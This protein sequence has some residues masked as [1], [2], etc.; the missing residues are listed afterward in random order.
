MAWWTV[1][2][3]GGGDGGEDDVP[4][5]AEV[6][7]GGP[8]FAPGAAP[9]DPVGHAAAPVEDD[10]ADVAPEEGDDGDEGAEVQGD[11]PEDAGGAEFHDGFG[12]D[13][14]AGA[15]DGEELR[16]A[17]H[18]AEGEGLEKGH[19]TCLCRTARR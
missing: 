14:V 6:L 7:A 18:D 4:A 3:D 17:L 2:A 15:A 8:D 1:A 11:F 13:K 16:G 9:G 19:V 5:H 10:V 12:E